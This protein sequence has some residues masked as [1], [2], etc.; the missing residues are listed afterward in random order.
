MG[1]GKV[2]RGKLTKGASTNKE[3]PSVMSTLENTPNVT[4]LMKQI[5]RERRRDEGRGEGKKGEKR[6]PKPV[7]GLM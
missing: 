3:V 7:A 1:S 6:V 4:S 2:K 5:Q